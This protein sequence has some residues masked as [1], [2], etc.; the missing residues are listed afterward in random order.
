MVLHHVADGADLLVKAA[1]ALHAEILRHRD[2]DTIDEIAIPD[3][4]EE[5]VRKA[6][7][8]QV[9]HR[10]LAQIMVDAEHR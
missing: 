6:E 5:R 2:L 7:I 9:L 10:L 3:R 8:K 1:A 4:L